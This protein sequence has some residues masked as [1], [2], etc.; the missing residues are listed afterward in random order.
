MQIAVG[1]AGYTQFGYGRT[2]IGYVS[3]EQVSITNV[4]ANFPKQ[5]CEF[6]IRFA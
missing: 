2:Q 6:G 3:A 4:H 5:A 1:N